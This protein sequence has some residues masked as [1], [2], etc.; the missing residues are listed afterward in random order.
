[1]LPTVEPFPSDYFE[2]TNNYTFLLVNAAIVVVFLALIFALVF[3][4]APIIKARLRSWYDKRFNIKIV[5]VVETKALTEESV[6]LL[7][8]EQF[9]VRELE[10]HNHEQ[11]LEETRFAA[12]PPP[13]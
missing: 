3:A 1:M 9:R 13:I 5:A 7:I 11:K 6:R 12:K 4:S 10:E 8:R 2:F